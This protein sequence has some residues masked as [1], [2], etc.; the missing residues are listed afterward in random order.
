MQQEHPHDT[1]PSVPSIDTDSD[2]QQAL[3]D[4]IEQRTPLEKYRQ[5][6][7][8][9]EDLHREPLSSATGPYRGNLM[10]NP[11]HS[12]L[13]AIENYMRMHP[14][15]TAGDIAIRFKIPITETCAQAPLTSTG[16][17]GYPTPQRNHPN[18]V[19]AYKMPDTPYSHAPSAAY[20]D[21]S[22]ESPMGTSV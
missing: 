22:Q 2:Y 18:N 21:Q 14:N 9:S 5:G 8:P 15:E 1:K 7:K 20:Q 12:R 13:S 19:Q 3:R 16:G 17:Y 6:E 10:T 4:G 11:R